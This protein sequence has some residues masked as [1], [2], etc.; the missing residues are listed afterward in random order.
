MGNKTLLAKHFTSSS[1]FYNMQAQLRFITYPF[2]KHWMIVKAWYIVFL[3]HKIGNRVLR[4]HKTKEECFFHRKK[5]PFI[6]KVFFSRSVYFKFKKNLQG[7]PYGSFY[8]FYFPSRATIFLYLFI[9]KYYALFIFLLA[10][11]QPLNFK[12]FIVFNL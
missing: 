7:N 10:N 11:L 4:C 2:K 8:N 1:R 5:N 9:Q 3:H 12:C 6:F